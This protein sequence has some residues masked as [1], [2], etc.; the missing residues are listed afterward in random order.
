MTIYAK[1]LSKNDQAA[2]NAIISCGARSGTHYSPTSGC[3][4]TAYW[5]GIDENGDGIVTRV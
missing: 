5:V 4:G 2:G 1:I 3:N